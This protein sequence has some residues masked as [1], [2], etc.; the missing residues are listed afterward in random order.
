M[1][2]DE[3]D[4]NRRLLQESLIEDGA[5]YEEAKDL[6]SRFWIE[7]KKLWHIVGPSIFSRL[8]DFSLNV[9]TQA[10]AGHLGNVELAA[11]SIALNV[12]LGFS[13]GILVIHFCVSMVAYWSLY[14]SKIHTVFVIYS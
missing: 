11:T 1:S 10:F 4:L 13:F 7:S 9:I 8:V 3:E 2:R 5:E 12:I 14:G 6:A